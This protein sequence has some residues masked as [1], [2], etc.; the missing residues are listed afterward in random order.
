VVDMTPHILVVDDDRLFTEVI[1]Q[2]L[3]NAGYRVSAAQYF[4]SAL[5]ILDQSPPP[6]LL[7][8]DLVM[9]NSINGIAL[10]RMARMRNPGVR[11]IL[12]TGYDLPCIDQQSFGPLMRKPLADDRLLATIA[13]ELA[14]NG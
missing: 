7:I 14:A 8:T 12:V 10:A 6:D 4:M 11:V 9:P 13:V 3:R 5:E 1:G 2:L